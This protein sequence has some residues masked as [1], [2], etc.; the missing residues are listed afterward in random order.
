ML[1]CPRMTDITA[2]FRAAVSRSHSKRESLAQIQQEEGIGDG[3][4][5]VPQNKRYISHQKTFFTESSMTVVCTNTV[6][7]LTIA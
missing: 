1:F 5:S 6:M 7:L 4:D 3:D 2:E